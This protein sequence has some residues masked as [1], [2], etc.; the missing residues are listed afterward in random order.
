MKTAMVWLMWKVPVEIKLQIVKMTMA[1]CFGSNEDEKRNEGKRQKNA[2][3]DMG[4]RR[5]RNPDLFLS[6]LDLKYWDGKT[7]EQDEKNMLE[8]SSS[9]LNLGLFQT[10]S[11]RLCYREP[12]EKGW[13]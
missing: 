9:W 13:R 8:H 4:Q 6:S 11:D 7:R 5:P 12:S 1:F 2:L 10:S 3:H